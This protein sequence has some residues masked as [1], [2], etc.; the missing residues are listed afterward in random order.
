M[1]TDGKYP[2]HVKVTRQMHNQFLSCS[3]LNSAGLAEDYLRLSII[4]EL[5]M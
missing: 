4:C 1:N 3:A 2:L 5:S